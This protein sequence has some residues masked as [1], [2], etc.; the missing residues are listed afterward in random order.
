MRSILAVVLTSLTLLFL[1]C[2]SCPAVEG[3]DLFWPHFPDPNGVV[4]HDQTT[5]TVSMPLWYWMDIANY[6]IDVEQNI[7]LLHP[8]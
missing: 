6:V 5:D 8:P 1:S 4:R 3:S 7:K 2:R